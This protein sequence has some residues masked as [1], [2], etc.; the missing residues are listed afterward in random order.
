MESDGKRVLIALVLSVGLLWG[1][2]T[3]IM[4]E[5]P[6]QQP[7]AT[8]PA[9]QPATT[10][11]ATTQSATPASGNTQAA[12][13]QAANPADNQPARD[14]TVDTPLYKA[15]FS[16]KGGT[17]RKMYLKKYYEKPGE[18]GGNMAL[19]D[20]QPRDAIPYSLGLGLPT[21]DANLAIRNFH[22]DNS[23]LAVTKSG[24]SISFSRTVKGV[25]VTKTYTF[26]PES[27]AFD[28]KIN[29]SNNSAYPTDL[30]PELTLTEYTAKKDINFY[31]FTGAQMVINGDYLEEDNGDLEDN[32]TH[33]GNISFISLSIP[34]FMGA[35]SPDKW[36]AYGE[37]NKPSFAGKGTENVMY[38][39]LRSPRYSIAPGKAMDLDFLV[40]YGPKDLKVLEPLGHHLDRAVDFGYMHFISKPMLAG[41]NFLDEYVKNYGVAIIIITILIKIVFWPLQNK[42]YESMKRMQ[43]LQ[44]QM[45][46]IREKYK[47]DKQEQNQQIMQLYKTYKVNPL[48]GCLPM[49]VQIP[50]FIAFYKVLGSAIELRHQP[51]M[52][53]INDLSAPDRLPIGLDIPFVGAGIPV[54]TLLMGA[55]MFLTQKM[56]PSTGDPTQQKM[57]MLMPVI[58]TVMF[59]NFPSGLVLY[60]FVQ[61]LLGIGQQYLVNRR[62]D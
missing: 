8:A 37:N 35:I 16:T 49:I 30:A 60:W 33:A 10:Q 20:L 58:F 29:L 41:L 6:K 11:A 54:L 27:Y 62:K 57:M 23:D 21:L 28:L 7:A 48:G 1:W 61:N 46:K 32:P 59:I 55:S 3:F 9:T 31:A 24:Q 15:V 34:Y 50:I 47:D 25:L 18:Q 53:W 22:S 26:D 17:L 45:K 42:S 19:L 36:P 14:I 13:A 39:T 40:F 43:K 5:K 2:S 12:A 56:T 4:P 52:L 38:S 44:P 51:F